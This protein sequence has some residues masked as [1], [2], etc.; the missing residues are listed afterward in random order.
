M[1][2]EGAEVLLA[3]LERWRPGGWVEHAG[4]GLQVCHTPK[5]GSHAYLHW[6]YPGLSEERLA[7]T[8]AVYDRPL[9]AEYRRYLGWSNGGCFFAGHL[10]LNGSHIREAA[11]DPLDRSG[12]GIG[13]PIS[14]DH[15][16]L[17]GRPA[18]AP[19]TAWMIG[20]ISGWS[21]QGSLL[22]HQSGEVR[23]CSNTDAGDVAAVWGSFGEM[24]L[25][26]FDRMGALVGDRGEA[27]VEYVQFLPEG[28]RR[29]EQPPKR[30]WSLRSL[31]GG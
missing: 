14:L 1:I 19:A 18:G 29:W 23:L 4:G 11:R 25:A 17:F 20:H 15:G 13:Q 28:G 16:N 3:R 22:L 10:G 27:L 9:P 7:Q 6:L 12:V 2:W 8:E 5:E 21:G 24:L 31:L 26:E 30:R